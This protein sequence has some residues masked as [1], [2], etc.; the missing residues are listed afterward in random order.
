[1]SFVYFNLLLTFGPQLVK[2]QSQS[3]APWT[4]PTKLETFIQLLL[5]SDFSDYSTRR[6]L[7]AASAS[8]RI[9]QFF[10]VYPFDPLDIRY[11]LVP[12]YPQVR[13]PSPGSY[14]YLG[15]PAYQLQIGILNAALSYRDSDGP[16]SGPLADYTA[17]TAA[18]GLLASTN[19]AY[20]D[21]SLWELSLLLIWSVYP[22]PPPLSPS[23]QSQPQPT[24][25]EYPSE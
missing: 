21:R 1:M 6:R 14:V 7:I 18:L 17:A 10:V 11:V 25:S 9:P 16:I 13:F 12:P 19:T 23:H 24:N 5:T 8:L 3:L 4:T 15:D 22:I 20:F 2:A